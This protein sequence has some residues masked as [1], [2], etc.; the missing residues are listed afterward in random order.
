M[1]NIN[2]KIQSYSLIFDKHFFTYNYF[3]NIV[4]TANDG[5]GREIKYRG[6]YRFWQRT[7]K[8]FNHQENIYRKKLLML[9]HIFQYHKTAE[10]STITT[11]SILISLGGFQRAQKIFSFTFSDIEITTVIIIII[12]INLTLQVQFKISF[13]SFHWLNTFC[14][15][16]QQAK[17][18]GNS[19]WKNEE[20]SWW[21]V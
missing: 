7:A 5:N 9:E 17:K 2:T 6:L 21:K 8:I 11:S 4:P 18:T 12:I 16:K 10:S 14:S 19:C 1:I 3:S 15:I 13:G 20:I